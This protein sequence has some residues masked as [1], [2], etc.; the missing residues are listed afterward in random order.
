MRDV[1]YTDISIFLF[2]IDEGLWHRC[3]LFNISMFLFDVPLL[4]VVIGHR[5]W[6]IKNID[7]CFQLSMFFTSISPNRCRCVNIDIKFRC[8]CFFPLYNLSLNLMLY[9]ILTSKFGNKLLKNLL[10]MRDVF[11]TDISIFFFDIDDGLWHRCYLFDISIFEKIDVFIR[12]L[13]T[14]K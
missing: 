4:E 6:N 14:K 12:C 9:V 7:V 1:F 3:Y 2:D 10:R 13:I 5:C 8:R 11:Y